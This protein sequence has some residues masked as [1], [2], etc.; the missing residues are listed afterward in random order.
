MA[1]SIRQVL[2]PYAKDVHLL[3]DRQRRELTVPSVL[4]S[5]GFRDDN[6]LT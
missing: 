4:R 6:G 5:A 2:A 3:P 1:T